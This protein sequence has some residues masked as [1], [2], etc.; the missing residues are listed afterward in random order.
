MGAVV[1]RASDEYSINESVKEGKACYGEDGEGLVLG[2]RELVSS[3]TPVGKSHTTLLSTLLHPLSL[4][5]PIQP[6]PPPTKPPHNHNSL[7]HKP[8]SGRIY[9]PSR[10]PHLHP[11][12]PTPSFPPSNFVR[13]ATKHILHHLATLKTPLST[14]SS[15]SLQRIVD[16]QMDELLELKEDF[17]VEELMRGMRELD[18][19]VGLGRE[20]EEGMAGLVLGDGEREGL[21]DGIDGEGSDEEEEEEEEGV[22]DPYEDTLVAAVETEWSSEVDEEMDA[23]LFPLPDDDEEDE[24]EEE[25]EDESEEEEWEEEEEEGDEEDDRQSPSSPT[26]EADDSVTKTK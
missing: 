16:T 1:V 20:I 13:L 21:A 19:R 9:K 11:H 25:E 17:E 24:D 10:P 3:H 2:E 6:P 18:V 26:S 15:S 4:H 23:A 22:F 5:N 7:A 12:K 14:L 8:S